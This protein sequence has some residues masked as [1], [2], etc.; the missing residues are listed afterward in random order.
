M[1]EMISERNRVK[2]EYYCRDF[3]VIGEPAGC[4]YSFDCDRDGNLTFPNEGQKENFEYAVAH[5][6]KFEDLGVVRRVSSYI[7][8]AK[9]RCHCGEVIELTDQYMGACECPRCNQWYNLF[10]QEL[11]PPEQWEKDW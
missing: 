6:D 2:K 11:L 9:G 8:P 4:G 7:E 10:G 3:Q 1:I 5:P